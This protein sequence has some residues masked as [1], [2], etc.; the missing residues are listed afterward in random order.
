MELP[1]DVLDAAY[2]GETLFG[3]DV[4]GQSLVQEFGKMFLSRNSGH[5][6]PPPA[7]RTDFSA[8]LVVIC[9]DICSEGPDVSEEKINQLA[10]S[11]DSSTYLMLHLF[12]PALEALV[13]PVQHNLS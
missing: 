11:A 10:Q 1:I 8:E 3:G 4:Y 12:H 9:S 13:T 7:V 5:D 2:Q 6:D